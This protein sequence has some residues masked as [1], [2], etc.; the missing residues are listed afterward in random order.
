ML[1]YVYQALGSFRGVFSRSATWLL[2][3][4]VV[5]GFLGAADI[6]GIS[7]FCRFWGVG[8]HAYHSFLH[9]FH[10]SAWSLDALIYCWTSF[11]ISQNEMITYGGRVVL[12]GDHTSVPKDGRRMPGVVTLK[13][14]SETQS[15]PSYFKGHFWGAISML[16][17]TLAAPFSL[18]LSLKLHQGQIHIGQETENE[19]NKQTQGTR[20]IQMAI[21]FAVRHG[22]PCIIILDA[23]FPSAAVFILAASVWSVQLRQPLLTLIVKA[24]KNCVAYFEAEQPTE[25]GPGRPP[26]YGQ[27]VNLMELFDHPHM[28]SK[29]TCLI[30]GKMEE[31]SIAAFNLVWEPTDCLIRFVL[32]LTS[33]GPI[34]LMC[35]DLAQDPCATLQLY[36]TRIRIEIMFDVLKNLLKAFCYRFWSKL[37]PLH[38]RRPK[39]N[40]TLT[41]PA[42]DSLPT[43]QSCWD[44]YERF[45]MLAV[46]AQGL[47]QL[48]SL[49]FKNLIWSQYDFFLRTQSRSLPSER[50]VKQVITHLLMV[51]IFLTF[52]PGAIIQ[53][54]RKHYLNEKSSRKHNPSPSQP[55]LIRAS[56]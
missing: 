27:K 32:A 53:T 14:D 11:V 12:L 36:C 23:F 9:F 31:V 47:L 22:L 30:Y 50:T 38:S 18:P 35:S 24:K 34:I 37:M 2:F 1:T 56:G 54:I 26:K 39:K 40:N 46:I 25:K 43:V 3:C 44:A 55:A 17:G 42:P 8:E 51:D 19:K 13:Q 45:V 4:M 16:V 5:L 41:K 49:K 7:S 20:L 52:A 21:D 29:T 6:I 48:L 10:S 28:F 33:Y 15:K